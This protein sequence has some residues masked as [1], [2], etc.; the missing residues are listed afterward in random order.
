MYNYEEYYLKNLKQNF[1]I[2]KRH[3]EWKCQMLNNHKWKKKNIDFKT[4][5]L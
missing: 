5:F 3:H 4:Y 1:M 2:M